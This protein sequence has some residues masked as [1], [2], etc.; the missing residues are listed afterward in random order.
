SVHLGAAAPNFSWLEVNLERAENP[1]LDI[2]PEQVLFEGNGY[3]VPERPGLGV[4]VD[5]SKLN[6]PLK[7]WEAPHLHRRDGSHTNW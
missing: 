2:F 7:L 4:E 3:A 1:N 5:E 6:E